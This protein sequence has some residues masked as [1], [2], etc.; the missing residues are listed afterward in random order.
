M[1]EKRGRKKGSGI[2]SGIPERETWDEIRNRFIY[3][4]AE[5]PLVGLRM[6]IGDGSKLPDNFLSASYLSTPPDLQEQERKLREKIRSFWR[7]LCARF[8]RAVLN[9][10]AGWFKRQAT[11]LRSKQQQKHIQFKTKVVYLFEQAWWGTRANRIRRYPRRKF[12]GRLVT[13]GFPAKWR[14][15]TDD[16]WNVISHPTFPK[17]A[18]VSRANR[19]RPRFNDATLAPA[20]EFTDAFASHVWKAVVDAAQEEPGMRSLIE[21]QFAAAPSYGV[22]K[23]SRNTI[24][25]DTDWRALTKEDRQIIEQIVAEIYGYKT[26][27]KA[28]TEIRKLAEQIGFALKKQA[29]RKR[30]V[31]L[32]TTTGAMTAAI[33]IIFA[34]ATATTCHGGDIVTLAESGRHASADFIVKIE[35]D[36]VMVYDI[37]WSLGEP[38]FTTGMSPTTDKNAIR[39]FTLNL[40][41]E[42]AAH[43]HRPDAMFV[44]VSDEY[45]MP[46]SAGTHYKAYLKRFFARD[47]TAVIK[48]QPERTSTQ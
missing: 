38:F 35:K 27:D 19:L 1:T 12:A 45:Y 2:L 25:P 48:Q 18:S 15:L 26:Q 8:E 21:Q 10:D 11:A 20:G 40:M 23:R 44:I 7:P 31:K 47:V 24:K 37:A 43:F 16:E 4:S 17:R 39:V 28:M 9:G 3:D 30:L 5:W 41:L 6:L 29:R 36:H 46:P 14:R 34:A 13:R 33:V 32:T 42:I 22:H